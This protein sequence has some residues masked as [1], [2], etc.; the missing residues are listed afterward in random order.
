MSAPASKASTFLWV[1][2]A[3]AGL[4][5]LFYLG[6]KFARDVLGRARKWRPTQRLNKET[7]YRKE[8][9]G[10][11]RTELPGYAIIEEYGNERSRADLVVCSSP[12]GVEKSQEKFVLELK[13]RLSSKA[14][15][16]R[17]IGQCM[18][19]KQFGYNKVV[20]LLIDIEPNIAAALTGRASVEGLAGFLELVE[21]GKAPASVQA[22][23]PS[24]A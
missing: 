20:L 23:T 8:V 12:L 4:A 15:M 9:A 6:R 10:F 5:V 17:V 18:G 19:Y 22:L 3:A 7:D 16:D 13:Y 14:E 21:V 2:A 24:A 1:A 11:L